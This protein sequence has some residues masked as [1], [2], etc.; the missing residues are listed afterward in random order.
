MQAVVLALLAS[1]LGWVLADADL[2][3]AR[4]LYQRTQYREALRILEPSQPK[5]APAYALTGQCY[6]LLEDFKKAGEA[7]EKAVAADSRNSV[8][9]DWLGRAYGKRAE[10]SSFFTAPSYASQ[11]RQHF[12][13]AVQL[14]PQNLEALDDLFEY[15]LEAPGFLGGGVEK[16][17][18]LSERL[19]EQAPAKYHSMQA[20]LAEKRK[21]FAAAEQHWRQAASSAPSEAG[22]LVD[23]ARFLA[24]QGRHSESD[25]TFERA[26]QLA[27][28]SP[29][30]KFQRA[31]TYLESGRNLDLA[32][33]LLQEYLVSSL[34]PDD[35]PRAEAE[36]LLRKAVT[37]DK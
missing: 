8:Y 1:A 31:R 2:E 29:Q 23:L 30:V 10:T 14:D 24:R 26:F 15:Y 12:E 5:T 25:T 21:Q 6:Y 19:R 36:R 20:R 4:E 22:R 34:T 32:R 9:W 18:P 37:S 3:R 27:P 7:L 28:Q 11:A 33:K 16:A 35:P 13:R 17:A